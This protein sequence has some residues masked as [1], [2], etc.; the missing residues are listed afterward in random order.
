MPA[1]LPPLYQG[2][3]PIMLHQAFHDALE[4]YEE[5]RLDAPE[6][7]VEVEG[8]SVAISAVFGRMRSCTDLIPVRT[9]DALH[10]IV[11]KAALELGD[12]QVTYAHAALLLRALCVERL[13]G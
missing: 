8:R 2:H 4:A 3:A 5:W 11:G 13:K 6:P 7:C 12:E 1:L 9:L 10:D